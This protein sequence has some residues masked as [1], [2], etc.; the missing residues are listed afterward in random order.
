[1]CTL[2]CVSADSAYAYRPFDLT[3]A[4]V[5]GP[6]EMELECGPFGYIVDADGRFLVVPSAILNFGIAEG[7][8][9]VIEGRNF[10]LLQSDDSRRYTLRDAAL[11]VKHV[12][13][14]GTLQERSGPSVG[15]EIG[16]LLPGV[17]IDSGAGASVAGLLSQRW[18]SFALHVNGTLEVTHDH[19]VAGVGGAILEGPQRWNVRPVAEFVLKQ[20]EDRTVSGLVGAIWKVRDNL[21]LDA[22]WRIARTGRDNQ[23]EF[24]AGFTWAIQLGASSSARP[25]LR[26]PLPF[27]ALS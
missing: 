2:V 6:R 1:M 12:L 24:R 3:D 11:S 19:R 4:A 22:G 8:E 21:S 27:R 5:A 25:A 15:I 16:L 13:R 26:S 18:S 20:D 9:I 14:R 10:F 7:W 23:R 17:G